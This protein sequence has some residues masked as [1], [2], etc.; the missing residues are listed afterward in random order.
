MHGGVV[1][2]TTPRPISTT[3]LL[4]PSHDAMQV[5]TGKAQ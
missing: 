2:T 4:E 5:A 3:A 1:E